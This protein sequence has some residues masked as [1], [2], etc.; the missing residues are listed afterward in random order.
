[1]CMAGS[2]G[3]WAAGFPLLR[4]IYSYWAPRAFEPHGQGIQPHACLGGIDEPETLVT[5]RVEDAHYVEGLPC[6]AGQ[7]EVGDGDGL[8]VSAG[9]SY[10]TNVDID[11]G[12]NAHPGRPQTFTLPKSNATTQRS[13]LVDPAPTYS[14]AQDQNASGRGPWRLPGSNL[15][16]PAVGQSHD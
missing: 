16:T 8:R 11:N 9:V 13:Q 10:D 15:G 14:S 1:M 6:W 2:Q 7:V 4:C 5:L 3:K 12:S